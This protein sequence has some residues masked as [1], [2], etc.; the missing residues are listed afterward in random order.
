MSY[1]YI[2]IEF[3][4]LHHIILKYIAKLSQGI[5]LVEFNLIIQQNP[6]ISRLLLGRKVKVNYYQYRKSTYFIV[7]LLA[8]LEIYDRFLNIKYYDL[9]N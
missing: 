5:Q 6:F 4:L 9:F 7:R 1:I 8:C 3:H 2:N